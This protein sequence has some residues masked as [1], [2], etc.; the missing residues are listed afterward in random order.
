MLDSNDIQYL[1]YGKH[2]V[3]RPPANRLVR[4]LDFT[5]FYKSLCKGINKIE[6]I[7]FMCHVCLVQFNIL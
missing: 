6:L 5:S 2:T 3:L 1:Q 7:T 4:I